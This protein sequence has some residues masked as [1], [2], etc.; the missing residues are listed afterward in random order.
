[1]YPTRKKRLLHK[2]TLALLV[3]AAT[4]GFIVGIITAVGYLSVYL[5][6]R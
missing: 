6:M 4:I 2:R 1:M 5:M 3:I